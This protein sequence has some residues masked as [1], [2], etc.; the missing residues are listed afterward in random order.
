M[1]NGKVNSERELVIRLTVR[2]P[3]GQQK[4]IQTVIDTGFDGWLTVPPA[5]VV[6][7][8][9]PWLRR[10]DAILADGSVIAFDVF[11]ATV[12]WDRRR[13]V[14]PI[15]EADTDPLVGSELLDGHELNARYEPGGEVTIRR[16][17]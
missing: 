7:L 14:I 2:G 11:E 10:S 13:L 16:I 5:I 6:Q 1:I 9:L 17:R 12:I 4:R 15:D 8:G 3:R